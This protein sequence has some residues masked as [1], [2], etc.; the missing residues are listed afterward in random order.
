MAVVKPISLAGAQN[1]IQ[2]VGYAA[3]IG[4]PLNRFLTISWY[5]A[6]LPGQVL[7]AQREVLQL[8]SKWLAYHGVTPAY[9]WVIENGPRLRYH[10][11]IFLHVPKHLARRFRNP[12]VN[13]WVKRTGA[14]PTTRGAIRMKR[15][16][17]E[18]DDY[19]ASTR[20]LIR[21][22]LKGIDLE[23]AQ[24]LGIDVDYESAGFVTGKRCGVSQNLGLAARERAAA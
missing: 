11:H 12:M 9:V 23:A 15:D 19:H 1:L 6:G 5:V 18:R 2:A 7:D 4:V 10:S 17:Y 13:R 20:H 16:R 24:L 22:F 3:Q 8:A 14:D 21:Y